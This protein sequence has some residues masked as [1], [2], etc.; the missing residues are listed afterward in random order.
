MIGDSLTAGYGLPADEAIPPRLQAALA[1][2]GIQS[3]IENAGVSGDTTAGGRARLDW[4]LGS[5]PDYV[6][7]ELGG[8]DALRGLSPAETEANLD[9]MLQ[10]LKTKSIKVLL[11]GMRAPPNLGRAYAQQFDAIYPRLAEKYGVPLYPFILDGVAGDLQ[12]NQQDGIHPN[13]KGVSIIVARLLPAVQKFL[14][15]K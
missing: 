14:N 1:A 10:V 5:K 6:I 4:A 3:I 12:L 2:R 7:L 8:N 9:A 15:S 11:A 13:A